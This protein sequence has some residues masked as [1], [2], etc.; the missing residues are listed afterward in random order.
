M[1]RTQLQPARVENLW[2]K[3]AQ[4]AI[5]A[6]PSMPSSL[7]RDWYRFHPQKPG[8]EYRHRK[9]RAD[10]TCSNGSASRESVRFFC[11]TTSRSAAIADELAN[12]LIYTL[13]FAN[14]TGIDQPRHHTQAESKPNPLSGREVHGNVRFDPPTTEEKHA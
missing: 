9:R 8:H 2:I 4:S 14:S 6:T 11:K 12:V 7:R 13:S 3:Q 10:G 5:C 1:D